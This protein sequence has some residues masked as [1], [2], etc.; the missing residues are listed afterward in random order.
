MIR[1]GFIYRVA[2]VF[3]DPKATRLVL[4][5]TADARSFD[6]GSPTIVGIPITTSLR[7]GPFRVRLRK[8]AGGLPATAEA[9][10]EQILQIPKR[11]FVVDH[12]DRAR[13][14]GGRLDEA[15]LDQVVS[16][17]VQ[18]LSP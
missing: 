18:V 9:A 11:N 4:V 16:A 10:C 1:R 15:V 12:L 7:S 2:R 5:M 6:A 8:G 17:V 13:P 3:R 14:L